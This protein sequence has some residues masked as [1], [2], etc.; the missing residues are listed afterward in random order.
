MMY[1]PVYWIMAIWEVCYQ[2]K[3][4]IMFG[5]PLKKGAMF[6]I[7]NLSRD[8]TSIFTALFQNENNAQNNDQCKCYI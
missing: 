8:Q 7:T 2:G 1:I 3:S 4:S 5:M 6:M